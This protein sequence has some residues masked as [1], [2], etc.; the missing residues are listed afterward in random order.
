MSFLEYVAN[1]LRKNLQSKEK[2]QIL[3]SLR[4]N[5][6]WHITKDET[7]VFGLQRIL[8]T[9]ANHKSKNCILNVFASLFQLIN[10][11]FFFFA[12]S[13]V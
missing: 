11:F 7:A 10:I 13:D 3:Q 8:N 1:Q 2:F 9:L 12:Y 5:Y 4:N 6:E